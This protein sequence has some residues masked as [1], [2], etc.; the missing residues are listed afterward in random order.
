VCCAVE[1]VAVGCGVRSAEECGGVRSGE[2]L[3][4]P[5]RTRRLRRPKDPGPILP[6]FTFFLHEMVPI[7]QQL[8]SSSSSSSRAR[9]AGLFYFQCTASG[10][11]RGHM[12]APVVTYIR[13]HWAAEAR[14][15][16]PALPYS[17]HFTSARRPSSKSKDL[18]WIR[19]RAPHL[20]RSNHCRVF[21][22]AGSAAGLLLLLLSRQGLDLLVDLLAV[23]ATR[24]HRH[25]ACGVAPS[26]LWW[27]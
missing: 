15:W 17:S 13:S 23:Q 20:L 3:A 6:H 19:G 22:M 24:P 27:R 25:W 4:P 2:L 21:K 8:A 10:T 14:G 1:A 9:G 5:N 12:Y 7:S 26:P 11:A 18:D 16:R